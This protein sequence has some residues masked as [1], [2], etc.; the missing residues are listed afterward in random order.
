MSRSRGGCGKAN[1]RVSMANQAAKLPYDWMGI[2]DGKVKP[3]LVDSGA[4]IDFN[5]LLGSRV[6]T[7][8]VEDLREYG[9]AVANETIS[10]GRG[11]RFLR[12]LLQQMA[13][14]LGR[15][16]HVHARHC[17]ETACPCPKQ[18]VWMPAVVPAKIVEESVGEGV[19]SLGASC[20][21]AAFLIG[22]PWQLTRHR[23][24][25]T[26]PDASLKLAKSQKFTPSPFGW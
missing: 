16:K 17:S 6:A 18:P 24:T 1:R 21:A 20:R 23:P 13:L 14:G 3:L 4:V 12:S 15:A 10:V 22:C 2:A 26:R 25:G 5:R 9:Y 7:S 8:P 11:E 19:V